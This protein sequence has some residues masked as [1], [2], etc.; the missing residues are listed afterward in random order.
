MNLHI[1]QKQTHRH[2]EKICCHG[3]VGRVWDGLGS[4]GMGRCKLLQLEWVVNEVL[5]FST[6]NY[7]QSLV[8]EHDARNYEK[9]N[10][11]MY[12]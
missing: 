4:L 11:Y 3:G 9:K 12:I 8:I 6:G 5:L 10:I 2:K 7:I 1:K